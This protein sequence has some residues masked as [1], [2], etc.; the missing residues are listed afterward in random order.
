VRAVIR[1]RHYSPH[2]EEAY[3][4]WIRRYILFH[5][6]RHPREMGTAEIAAFLT[7][8]AVKAHVAASRQNQALSALL[9]LYRHVLHQ[10]LDPSIDAVR[11]QRPKRLPTVLTPAEVRRVL[12]ALSGTPRLMS[13]LL[14]GSGLRLQE[15]VS[16]RVKDIDFER[17]EITVREA[18]GDKDRVTM[19]PV[20]LVEPLRQHLELV[21]AQHARDLA[22][23]NGHVP[24]PHALGRKLPSASREWPWQYVFPSATLSRNRDSG[25]VCRHHISP[26]TLQKAVHTAAVGVGISRRVTCHTFRHSFATHLLQNGYDIRTVQELLGHSSVGTTMMYLLNKSG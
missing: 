19:L 12:E 1:T 11:A 25:I 17:R 21:R 6:K 3:V 23:G 18:K 4:A 15:C 20:S 26:A 10:P 2:T 22:M 16:L 24:L 9:F 13:M 7:H 14:Y 5:D 8:L